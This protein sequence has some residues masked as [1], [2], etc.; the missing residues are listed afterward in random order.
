MS[1]IVFISNMT[2]YLD[3]LPIEIQQ[4]V[5]LM[6]SLPGPCS[7]TCCWDIRFPMHWF[8]HVSGQCIV[9][10]RELVFSPG[11]HVFTRE[12]FV[13]RY[14]SGRRP[15]SSIDHDRIVL[16]SDLLREAINLRNM[17]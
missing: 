6:S 17:R 1:N 13:S 15:R 3:M 11:N 2:T 12:H 9:K 5:C 10:D 14:I 4:R 7:D 8:N 16:I